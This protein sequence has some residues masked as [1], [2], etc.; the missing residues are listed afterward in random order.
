MWLLWR[1]AP[2]GWRQ[3]AWWLRI[4]RLGVLPALLIAGYFFRSAILSGWLLFPSPALNLHLPWSVPDELVQS[5]YETNV[6]DWARMPGPER[7]EIPEK[8]FWYWFPK[9]HQVFRRSTAHDSLWMGIFAL[10]FWLGRPRRRGVL[11][12]DWVL[13]SFLMGMVALNTV[14]WF[15]GAPDLRFAEGL[16]WCW[17]ALTLAFA[18]TGWI[19]STQLA[20]AV[21]I[22]AALHLFLDC[23]CDLVPLV[24]FSW[25]SVARST[26]ANVE[27]IT[28]P[29][30]QTPPLQ[31]YI[32][33]DKEDTAPGDSPL[34]ASLSINP[35]L[36][37]R[38][39]GNIR[40]GFWQRVPA[41]TP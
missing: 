40:A 38:E 16:F 21:S 30:G 17:M 28:V 36:M 29:N 41:V 26:S 31:V 10:M 23:R 22:V 25:T 11:P 9:W 39:P 2:A 3:P 8:G 19:R 7:L 32:S 27:L 34:P 35:N 5:L 14:M 12:F 33:T 24:D 13:P 18:I 15:V 6:R 1:D 20:W 4:L 37:W